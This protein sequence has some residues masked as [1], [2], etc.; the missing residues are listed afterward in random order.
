MAVYCYALNSLVMMNSSKEAKSGGSGSTTPP[1]RGQAL[2]V[3]ERR[4]TCSPLATLSPGARS[5][6][7]PR[8]SSAF[9]FPPAEQPPAEEAGSSGR[10]LSPSRWGREEPAGPHQ[11]EL[12]HVQVNQRVGLFEA[13]IQAALRSP[14]LG[15]RLV[16]PLVL[17]SPPPGGA[18]RVEDKSPASPLP[19]AERRGRAVLAPGGAERAG[20]PPRA[21]GG[22]EVEQGGGFPGV[23]GSG[24]NGA[25]STGELERGSRALGA[26]GTEGDGGG[27]GPEAARKRSGAGEKQGQEELGK[28]S[29]SPR[30][31]N[32]AV[33]ER[34]AQGLESWEEVRT[35]LG[36]AVRETRSE[37]DR[38]QGS[39]VMERG[40]GAPSTQGSREMEMGSASLETQGESPQEGSQNCGTQGS[41]S[42]LAPDQ[43]RGEEQHCPPTPGCC[44]DLGSP[45]ARAGPAE[46][47]FPVPESSLGAEDQACAPLRQDH[48]GDPQ[49][50]VTDTPTEQKGKPPGEGCCGSSIPAVII[51]DLGG[52]EEE[53]GESPRV[54]MPI[55]KLSSSSASSTGFSSSWEESEEDMSS[56]PERTLDQAQAFLQT[57][58]QHKPRVSKSWRKI[59]NMVQW[60]PFVM[61]FKKKYPWIQLAGHAGSFK[62]AANGRILKKHCESEQRCLDRLM[63]DILKPFV[64]AYHGDV[65]KDGERYNQ[66]EDLLAEFDSPCVMDC[67]MGVRTYLEEELTKA[68]KKPSLRK[69]M[70]QK[71]IEVDPNA[72]TEEENAQHAVT[73]PRYMQWRETISSTATLGFRIEGIKNEDGTVNRDFKKTRTKE[74]VTEAFREFTKGNRNIL[75]GYLNRLKGIRATLEKSPFFKCHEVIGS[76]LLFIHDQKEQA[77]VW[78]IDFGKTTPLPE[79]QFLQHNVPWVEGNREDGYLWGLD[80]LIE[81][82]MELSQS[83][84]LH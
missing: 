27:P 38:A 19:Q 7:C 18:P 47:L 33:M 12:Q 21:Q 70:Y 61:S 66:M 37:P 53:T 13:H 23:Q 72:P 63:N 77:K 39:R 25:Q 5:P 15:R 56:D 26:P 11:R 36:S 65:M 81:I 60:S 20:E 8:R 69:D 22:G 76:S 29:G 80:N 2:Q 10:P 75:N 46:E 14:R 4:G 67:K 62:A 48:P 43:G 79:G 34:G 1:P 82:L 73:K 58:D 31:Q 3:P 40:A 84:D 83:E 28:W 64:P 74:Q 9:L 24:H 78:M 68:R 54:N 51:T 30:A 35:V 45:P 32:S 55:R 71:M 49:S 50:L 44:G 17:R 52:Q 41:D 59:K 57:L 42:S 6:S 16:S